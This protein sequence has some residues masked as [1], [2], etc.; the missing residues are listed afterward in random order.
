MREV[1]AI[2]LSIVSHM[3]APMAAGKAVV[4]WRGAVRSRLAAF[5]VWALMF[6]G[7]G[8]GPV[9]AAQIPSNGGPDVLC[10]VYRST[11]DNRPAFRTYLQNT[12]TAMLVKLKRDGVLASFQI[13]YAPYVNS[14]SWDAMVILQFSSYAATQKWQTIERTS[15][16]GLSAEGFACAAGRYH[17]C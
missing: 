1:K 2:S 6:A 9:L 16:G 17:F 14:D 11:P 10:I 3:T 5:F 15:P 8:G 13:L 7:L 4:G 12:Q